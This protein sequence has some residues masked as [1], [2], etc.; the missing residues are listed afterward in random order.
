MLP[1]V[2]SFRWLTLVVFV[3]FIL[4]SCFYSFPHIPAYDQA[5]T[6]YQELVS[7]TNE[8]LLANLSF[9]PPHPKLLEKLKKENKLGKLSRLEQIM[10]EARINVPSQVKRGKLSHTTSGQ[11]GA[12]A[13][14][15]VGS[16]AKALA[17]LV[18]FSDEP[19]N[20][21]KAYFEDLLFGDHQG[22][23]RDY[24]LTNSY[25]Y[26]N[27]Q[28]RLIGSGDLGLPGVYIRLPQPITYYASN[29]Y[30]M[31]GYPQNSQGLVRDVINILN[32]R[33][34]DWSPYR[35]PDGTIPYLIIIHAGS[36]A[37]ITGNP[38]D[39]WSHKWGLGPD[40][41]T[42]NTSQGPAT[43]N[44]YIIAP[45]LQ[46]PDS[47]SSSGYAP[48]TVGVVAH[49]F[50]H[51][52][53]LPDLYDTSYLTQGVGLWSLMSSGSWLGPLKNGY[54]DGS[55]PA[56]LDAF[57]KM[58]LG[59]VG[60]NV[61]K[62][63]F[64]DFQ[65]PPVEQT[66]TVMKLLPGGQE[67]SDYFLVENRQKLGYDAYLPGSG[68]LVWH[69]DSTIMNPDSTYW[70][71]DDVNSSSPP[72]H[73]LVLVEADGQFNLLKDYYD[74]NANSG[75]ASDPFP[76]SFGKTNWGPF[77]SPSSAR[78]DDLPS[79]VALGNIT[80]SNTTIVADIAV[81]SH[82]VAWISDGTPQKLIAGKIY[83]ASV[84]LANTGSYSWTTEG[85]NPFRL[86]YHIFDSKGNKVIWDG[87]RIPLS[88]DV[89]P[90]QQI[91]VTAQFQAPTQPGNYSLQWDMVQEGITWFSSG[92]AP[93]RNVGIFI[94]DYEVSWSNDSTPTL[95]GTEE[96]I[97]VPLT[98]TN[99]G[100]LTWMST[101]ANP[102]RVSYHWLDTQ[103]KP[104]ILDGLRT[105][106]PRDVAPGETISVNAL[107]KA[108]SQPGTY[109][110][111]WDLVREG[112]TWFSGKGAT[113]KDVNV[114]V[115]RL[116]D[117]NWGTVSVP[118]VM[119]TGKSYKIN[120]K[121]TNT[122]A[123]TW[124]AG[125]SN[126]FRLSYHW[127]DAAGN[128][129]VFDGLRTDLSTDVAP[130]QE[131]GLTAT[132]QA[133]NKAGRY[134]LKWDMVHEGVT[135]FSS[136]GVLTKDLPV[137]VTDDLVQ[138]GT[139]TVP[140]KMATGTQYQATI[141]VVN[142]GS[143]LWTKGGTNPVQ[144]SYHWRDASNNQFVLW[145]GIRTELPRDVLPGE[146]VTL[147][148]LLKTPTNPGSYFLEWDL[149]RE[150]VAW[151]SGKG[152]PILSVSVEVLKPYGV[153]WL[154]ENTP[155]KMAAKNLYQVNI[156]LSNEGGQTWAAG[157]SNPVHLSYHWK[158]ASGKDVVWDGLRTALPSDIVPGQQISLLATVKAPESAGNYKL[159]WDMVHEGI[160]WFS[161]QGVA[162][163]EVMVSVPMYEVQWMSHNT[164]A[165]LATGSVYPVDLTIA[166]M[167]GFVWPASGD[168][169]VRL[170][171]HWYD[172]SGNVVIWDGL[173][174]GMP[175]DVA[176]GQVVTLSAQVKVPDKPGTYTLKWDLVQE[177]VTWFSW[178]ETKTLDVP[179][180]ITP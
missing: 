68:L 88:G 118:E 61:P 116:Y 120:I 176:P 9:A 127:V 133:P 70:R 20:T 111:R 152:S 92:G 82:D 27:L 140:Q 161:W 139:V 77:T 137:I 151:F 171:Y 66:S 144:L 26:F 136:K 63:G 32:S 18:D 21:P 119:A 165:S 150:G 54:L 11:E 38:N 53:G 100:G 130:S 41:V 162:T 113:P 13:L 91:T 164:P 2:R 73:G 25:G 145:D 55:C 128:I 99:A 45:E 125:G 83:T 114:T 115:N 10:R 169:P 3:T 168:K 149:V 48:A 47:G 121:L 158:D 146:Q 52:L 96:T 138:W 51:L 12:P 87:F 75:D 97:E 174:T 80:V 17:V 179:V 84:T 129:V 31:G 173:R 59:W 42:V 81:R 65:F 6:P 167:G 163:K 178:K 36:D 153:S 85:A 19:G 175:V 177:G 15:P 95:M 157:G 28:G 46:I 35:S 49:E 148:P 1:N 109:I 112:V 105:G 60:P 23:L 102:V 58:F 141:T 103:G 106:L 135:W 78:F 44:E 143:T 74:Y 180:A 132:V 104:V 155:I 76:G 154:S 69:V 122:G 8:G 64:L 134:I 107:L 101:G 147:T 62:T 39:L 7:L 5:S 71:L 156:T 37:A 16:Q 159:V 124:V 89:L 172:S 90:G 110:L 126:P 72:H 29:S 24:Y 4:S 79:N 30:G 34:F 57:S 170:S 50:G 117:L 131:T 142:D 67:A 40:A 98:I 86:S 56:E 160:T 166:N 22:T 123:Q 43:I 33:G 108:P 93:T 14:A 94:P